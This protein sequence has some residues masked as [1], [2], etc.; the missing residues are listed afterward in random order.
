MQ[1]KKQN[2]KKEIEVL[3]IAPKDVDNMWALVEFQ[4]KEALKYE[5]IYEANIPITYETLKEVLK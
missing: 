5:K 2:I 4:I 1:A 3:A